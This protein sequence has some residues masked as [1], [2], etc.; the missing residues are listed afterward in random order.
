MVISAITTNVKESC[1]RNVL[2]YFQA[3]VIDSAI[4]IVFSV[5]NTPVV[6]M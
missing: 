4:Y 5:V 3:I 6:A 2:S 1:K